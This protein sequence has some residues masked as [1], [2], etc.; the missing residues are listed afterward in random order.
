MDNAAIS[1]DSSI[2]AV[3]S[4]ANSWN[5]QQYQI[6]DDCSL[7]EATIDSISNLYCSCS[8]YYTNNLCALSAAGPNS[9]N[10]TGSFPLPIL[11]SVVIGLSNYHYK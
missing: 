1:N 7:Y 11:I 5:I 4:D 9:T 2:F 6:V 3:H 8:Q 10:G